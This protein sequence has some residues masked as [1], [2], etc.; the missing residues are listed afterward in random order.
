LVV[1]EKGIGWVRSEQIALGEESEINS[2]VK[3]EDFLVVTGESVPFYSD[4]EG[5]LVSGWMGMSTQM[6]YKKGN[7]SI[8][9]VPTRKID[10]TLV[11]QEAWL[12][13]QADVSVGY[14]PYTKK[15]IITQAT[16]LLDLVYDWTGGWYGRN[17]TTILA[18]LFGCFGF[19]FPSNGV[20]LSMFAPEP[21]TISPEAGKEAQMSAIG[22]HDAF[23][24]IQ[25]SNSG[26]S[27]LFVGTYNNIPIVFDT[28]GYGY[29]EENGDEFEI[30]RS[31]IG[32]VEIPD[33]MLKQEMTFIELK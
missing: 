3:S 14:L 28:H 7:P 29:A 30:R 6:A 21:H 1:S 17:H 8:V 4:K 20:L 13:E 15:N 24:T 26:H 9:L 5:S 27:Q 18:D 16:K 19:K 10:G 32:T 25:V 11:I 33:Y 31:V 2:L 23:T 22:S 12:K